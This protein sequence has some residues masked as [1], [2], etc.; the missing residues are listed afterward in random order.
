MS[1]QTLDQ[2][3]IRERARLAWERIASIRETPDVTAPYDRYFQKMAEFILEMGKLYQT[4]KENIDETF[5][6]ADWQ[7]LNIALYEDILPENYGQSFGNPDYA[8]EIL[9]ETHGK[10]L[11]FLYSELR[12]MIPYA[13]E[14]RLEEMTVLS[15]LF[16]EV[17]NAF[18]EEIPG[19]RS[20]QQILYWFE[21][22]YTDL[23]V[24]RRIREGV[25]PSLDFAVRI[26]MDSDLS[27]PRYLY[28]YG[29]YISKNELGTWEYLNTL[30]EETIRLMADTYTEGYRMGFVLGRKDLSKKS[31]VNLRYSIGFERVIRQAIQNF[32]KMGLSP[33]IYRYAPECMN[34]KGSKI[35]YLGGTANKQFDYDHRFDQAIFLDKP[36]VERKLGV[37]RTTYETY[38]ELAAKHAGPACMEVFGEEPFSPKEKETACRLSEKQQKLSVLFD[39]ESVQVTNRYIRGD[40]RSF[41]IIAFPVPEI[42]DRYQEIFDE[43]IRIN[44]LD[45]EHYSLI[46]QR[47]IDALD[48]GYAV[49]I[50]GRGANHT[51]LTVMLHELND[52]ETETNFENC[53]ADVNIPLGE[54]FTSPKLQGTSGVLEVGEVYLEDFYYRNLR[55]VFQDG[56]V[57]EYT[58]ENFPSEEQN[59]KYVK[60]NVLFHHDTLPMGEFAI[61]TNT[62]AYAMAE[63][64]QI[65]GKLPILIAEKMGPHF[66]VGDT[67]Y[68]WSEDVKVY[69]PNG[70][71]IVAKDNEVSEKR[72]EDASKAYFGCHLDIT[73]PYKE[74][75]EIAVLQRDGTE[76]VVI[77]EGRFVLEGTEELNQAF[78]E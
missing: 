32:Q 19:Y 63:K 38:R 25:D 37:M 36:F 61:G 77:R 39:N 27:D 44:T 45:T 3:L 21:S 73:I 23:F 70:K 54:V 35:G 40:E 47:I 64:Y 52:Q 5:E 41:T 12:A 1:E 78:E 43:T 2:E 17:Y 20:I 11:S 67:C 55:L 24:A 30:P 28:R 53:G 69:N 9:G 74:L 14:Q 60:E 46:Q 15:E 72:K 29:E 76:T 65:G 49:R 50:K 71:E 57:K 75:G 51:D 31:T 6:L 58:C 59:R 13:F 56:M 7:K 18:E 10:L 4:R 33:V 26:V 48:E 68:S 42:G 16:I 66:A 62:F 22:D 34:R 8:V